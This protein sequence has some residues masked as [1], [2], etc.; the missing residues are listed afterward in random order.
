M[1]HATAQR[2]HWPWALLLSVA[3]ACLALPMAMQYSFSAQAAAN[4]AE[5]GKV[6]GFPVPPK[7]ACSVTPDPTTD[8]GCLTPRT[9][10]LAKWLV[11]QGWTT[12]CWDEHAWSP[13]SDHP[14]GRACD[15]FPGRGGVRPTAEQ[16]AR[17][18]EL[19]NKLKTEAIANNVNYIIWY[20]KIWSVEHA[21]EGWRKYDGGG[22]YNAQEIIGGHYDHLH[23]S[24]F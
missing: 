8:R 13:K 24:V 11:D 6:P 23:I 19:A 9:A 20:G 16:K 3:L 22:V 10:V 14:L 17:G 12:T 7:E 4:R 1:R 21:D 18:D 5:L 15:V 2:R